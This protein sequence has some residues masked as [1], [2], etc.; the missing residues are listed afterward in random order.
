[1]VGVNIMMIKP[2]KISAFA[3]GFFSFL[4]SAFPVLADDTEIYFAPKTTNAGS[5]N[6]L[7]VLDT[8]GSM[9]DHETDPAT[10]QPKVTSRMDDLKIAFKNVIDS[11]NNVNVGIMRFSNGGG[12]VLYPVTAIDKELTDSS[13][14]ATITVT[15]A[16]GKGANDAYQY[17]S[18]GS[19]IDGVNQL[20]MGHDVTRSFSTV[21]SVTGSVSQGTDDAEYVPSTSTFTSNSNILHTPRSSTTAASQINGIRFSSGL[22]AIPQN[23]IVNSAILNLRVIS[24]DTTAANYPLSLTIGGELADQ[25]TFSAA[26]NPSTRYLNSVNVPVGLAWNFSSAPNTGAKTVDVT[27]L[28]SSM[29]SLPAWATTANRNATFLLAQ[30]TGNTAKSFINIGTLE[31]STSANRPT[32]SVQYRNPDSVEQTITALRFEG[33]S[34][35]KGVTI[36]SAHVD[37][38]ADSSD[39]TATNLRFYGE[40]ANNSAALATTANNLSSR[41]KTTAFVDWAGVPAWTAGGF[42]TSEYQSPDIK[43]IIQEIVNQGATKYSGWCGDNSL[44]ILVTSDLGRRIA[45]AYESGSGYAPKLTV[46][47]DPSTMNKGNTCRNITIS[48][49][50]LNST[51]DIE[52]IASSP[53]QI[54]TG[55]STINLATSGTTLRSGGFHFTNLQIPSSSSITSA[56]LE[57]TAKA[58]DSSALSLTIKGLAADNP[59]SFFAPGDVRNKAKTAASVSWGSVPSW[60]AES[61][62]QSA[63]IASIIQELVNRSGWVNGNSMSLEVSGT[64]TSARRRAYAWDGGKAKA[65]RLIVKFRD[66]GTYAAS[67]RVRDLLKD[68]VDGFTAGGNTPSQDTL[69]E[70]ALYFKGDRVDYGLRR[71]G[72]AGTYCAT[73]PFDGACSGP[74][75]YTRVSS[76]AS[77]VNGASVVPNRPVG[78]TDA[79]LDA[80]I[81]ASETLPDGV[82]YQT[83]V[84]SSASCSQSNAIVFLTDG[85]PN[86]AHSNAKVKA[87]TG[88]SSCAD[89]DGGSDCVTELT[90]WMHNNGVTTSDGINAKITTHTIGLYDGGGA[91]L[92]SVATEGGGGFYTAT[93]ADEIQAAFTQIVNTAVTSTGTTFV[94]AGTAVNAFDRTLN[95]DDLF[96]SVF[97]PEASPRWTGNVK[98]YKL[99][100]PTAGSPEIRDAKGNN[101]IDASGFFAVGSRSYWTDSSVDDGPDVAKGGASSLITDYDAR[102]VYTYYD[103]THKTLSDAVNRITSSTA[104]GGLNSSITKA[105]FGVPSYSD[106]QFEHLVDWT[107]GRNYDS[108]DS[109]ATPTDTRFVFAD[110]LH[111][112]PVTITYKGTDVSPDMTVF[113]T[114]NSGF[115]HAINASNGQELFSYIP[116]ELLPIQKDLFTNTPGAEHIFGLDSTITPWIIDPDGDGLVLDS[117]GAAQSGNSVML[118]FGM[119][120][121]GRGVYALDVTDRTNPK[122]LWSK[123]GGIDTGFNGLG[124]TWSQPV[125]AQIN[126][127]GTVKKVIIFGGGYDAQQD[128]VSVRTADSMGNA[129]FIVD[130]LDGSLIWSGGKTAADYTKAFIDMSY[131]IPSQLAGADVDGDGLMDVFFV[132][133]MGGQVWRFDIHNGQ[134][135]SSLVTGGVIADL[136]A[137]SGTPTAANARRFYHAPSLYVGTNGNTPFLGVAIGSGYRA[138]PLNDDVVDRFY[139]I[140][141]YSIYTAPSTYT[142]LTEADLYD[143]TDNT[144]QIGSDTQKAD[145]VT[146]LASAQGWFIT[147]PNSGEKVLSTP[148]IADG[149]AY[150]ATFEPVASANA[151]TPGTGK[152]RIY[153]VGV[154]DATPQVITTT[155]GVTSTSRSYT[156]LSPGIVD[157]IK[158]IWTAA[159]LVGAAGTDVFNMQMNLDQSLKRIYWNENRK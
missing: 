29:V 65:A 58:S 118:Y 60:T 67:Y 122:I 159:G 93:N 27:S 145:A 152:N 94:A 41:T 121:G 136:G 77:L 37:F 72:M 115:L 5:T 143:A 34:I 112:R 144:I 129:I 125:K 83:P 11:I 76:T 39:S 35:P 150:F 9:G 12:P 133:D 43:S 55:G 110:P 28:V 156:T 71:G 88:V 15:S 108:I 153:Q 14:P 40:L 117:G 57:L 1:M 106:S 61:K 62:Y 31:Q 13:L 6:I 119:R 92:E 86:S 102:K 56:Y 95:R 142:K 141:Q 64:S 103:S 79:N 36:T 134:A 24:R 155:D 75:A 53:A 139:T 113:V 7:F 109:A 25:G 66:D 128:N 85:L 100:S 124:E 4:V 101:A 50:I 148:V 48:R 154:S 69:Y 126:I 123:T 10:G 49:Q 47:Y 3:A 149:I 91:W 44:T 89:H 80:A 52:D 51:D 20:A 17:L 146:Q 97:K 99:Y 46:Q 111:S 54:S 21:Y 22:S 107:L 96:F 8:S 84:I 59:G 147:L 140:R 23:A 74:F 114:T 104:S 116:K 70:A 90:H 137:A 42:G 73:N 131:G 81:C 135:A 38:T 33:V 120:R 157:N 18:D 68:T 132:G 138:H 19:V 98:K 105:M 127:N 82:V 63:D 30:T 151:C 26:S 78:C 130:A 32:L 2:N 45:K 87:L 16:T 158:G